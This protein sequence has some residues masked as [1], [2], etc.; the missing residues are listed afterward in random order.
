MMSLF[1]D[2]EN[3]VRHWSKVSK[4]SVGSGCSKLKVWC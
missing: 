1:G 4:W 2:K 3:Y